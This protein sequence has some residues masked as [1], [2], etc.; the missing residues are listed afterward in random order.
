MLGTWLALIGLP[1]PVFA[2][3][4]L[5]VFP[6]CYQHL[7]GTA[8]LVSVGGAA[9]AH[10]RC[11][12][13]IGRSDM[14]SGPRTIGLERR[15][16]TTHRPRQRSCLDAA[17]QHADE[18]GNHRKDAPTALTSHIPRIQGGRPLLILGELRLAFEAY[19]VAM[20]RAKLMGASR[21]LA[22]SDRWSPTGIARHR[23]C[24]LS[25]MMGRLKY[26]RVVP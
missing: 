26:H 13:P 21:S 22:L 6:E 12:V 10:R 8:T 15:S 7:A 9:P 24:A 25:A 5:A 4:R 14:I 18:L 23:G 19:D 20:L 11:R 3:Y 2:Y 1:A 16:Q 17:Y